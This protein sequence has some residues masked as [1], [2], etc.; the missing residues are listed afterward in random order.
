MNND[1]HYLMNNNPTKPYTSLHKA[2]IKQND[3]RMSN[4]T[5]S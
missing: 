4:S 3:I 1:D 2:T 5:S